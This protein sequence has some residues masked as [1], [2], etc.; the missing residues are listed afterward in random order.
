M[1]FLSPAAPRYLSSQSVIFNKQTGLFVTRSSEW[2]PIQNGKQIW[3]SS[4]GIISRKLWQQLLW[5]LAFL[6]AR[7]TF[8]AQGWIS[9]GRKSESVCWL[10]FRSD[11]PQRQKWWASLPLSSQWMQS[12]IL[13][14]CFNPP[15]ALRKA[16]L[17][18]PQPSTFFH[19]R[20][21]MIAAFHN[22]EEHNSVEM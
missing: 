19:A 6:T 7:V 9:G 21:D 13:P 10:Y 16:N 1:F 14:H 3:A 20:R 5:F 12:L 2:R 8:A 17:F 18:P 22:V 4:S 15:Q 11:V